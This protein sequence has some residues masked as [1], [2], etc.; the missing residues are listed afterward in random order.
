MSIITA[1]YLFYQYAPYFQ[2]TLS[3]TLHIQRYT[4]TG[5]DIH[6]T[7]LILFAILLIP[8]YFTL[9]E[10]YATKSR[11]VYRS[12]LKLPGQMPD[13]EEKIASLATL[14]KF[15]F[16]PLMIIWFAEHISFLL[17]NIE[18]F[19]RTGMF[20][21]HGY[22]LF[23]HLIL[24][25]DVM[26]YTM[27]YAIE[28]PRLNNEIRSVEPTILGWAVALMC[29]PPFNGMTT[30]MIG[31]SSEDMP[32]YSSAGIQIIAANVMLV[33]MAIY[34]WA[35]VALNF[36]ASN[37]TNRGIVSGGPY[38]F[39]RHPAYITKNMF[40]WIGAMP[41]VA[42]SYG[43]G[44]EP[45][46]KALIALFGWTFIYYLRAITEERHLLLDPDYVMYCKKVKY[47]FIPGIY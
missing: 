39:V 4:F 24:F 7:G 41:V 47:K 40:W 25:A 44:T 35:S 5:S 19:S 9:P 33:L 17:I 43:N 12:I 11:R 37:L 14:V 10:N 15:F 32:N 2:Q 21:P 26:F 18:R 29:Y 20:F 30:S 3:K 28:H 23:F 36:K 42:V 31:W 38:R 8:Y 46:V 45:F 34:A 27:G 6:L 16:L 13:K 1:G 22:F